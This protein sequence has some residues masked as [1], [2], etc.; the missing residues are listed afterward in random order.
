MRRILAAFFF[1]F[2][3]PLLVAAQ[4][5]HRVAIRAG[6]LIDGRS[7]KPVE[8]AL[9]LIESDKIV[10]VTPGGSP[11]SGVDVIDLSKSTVLPGF[12]D[13]H[14]HV[15]LQGDITA[16]E[17]DEQVLKQSIPYRAILA[18]RNAQ[19]AL[20]HGLRPCATWKPKVPCTPTWT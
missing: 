6:K 17:Y 20:S 10:S 11:P 8:N 7:D 5:P 15:L 12:I 4:A 19:I 14:T 3:I 1:C 2:S 18:A 16:A 9:I 13:T